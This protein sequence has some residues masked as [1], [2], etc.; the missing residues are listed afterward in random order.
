MWFKKRNDKIF[1]LSAY[2]DVVF[3]RKVAR[4]EEKT[5]ERY[6]CVAV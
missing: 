1:S 6:D 4:T 2:V 5:V 3:L